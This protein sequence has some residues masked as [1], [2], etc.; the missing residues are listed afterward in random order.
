MPKLVCQSGPNAGH[1][2]TIAKDLVVL[3]RQ[4]S[5]DVQIVDTM[6]SRAHCH[7]RRDGKLWSLIDLGSRNGTLLN[8]KRIT[9]RQLVYGDRIRIGQVEYVLVK[10]PGDLELKDLLSKYDVGEKLGEGGMGIVYKA[11]QR[12]M[13]R[14]V[15]LKIL[16]PKYASRPKFVEQF[17]RE[18]RAAGQLNHPNIIQVHDVASENEIHYFSMEFVDGSTCMQL[19]KADGPFAVPEA[20]EI[21]RQVARALEYAH[22][23]RLIHQDIKP[24]NVMIGPG[25]LVK[26]ADLGI[27]KTFD[28][29][30]SEGEG[31]KVMGTPHYMAPEAGLGKKIDHRVDIYSLGATLYHLL[32]GKTPY[33]GT[34]ATE[35]LKA[36]VMDPLP[37]LQDLNPEVSD[38]VCAL[39]ERMM[40]KKAEERY[41]SANE[42]ITELERLQGGSSLGR[43]R[44]PGHETMIL[45][46]FASGKAASPPGSMA[47]MPTTGDHTPEARPVIPPQPAAWARLLGWGLALAAIALAVLALTLPWSSPPAPTP[48]MPPAIPQPATSQTAEAPANPAGDPGAEVE[49]RDAAQIFALSERLRREDA[50]V[51]AR[52]L[53]AQLGDIATRQ[54][55]PGNRQ[56]V[57]ELRGR[58]EDV[59]RRRRAI[60]DHAAWGEVEAE[61]HRLIAERNWD[62]ALRRIDA[63]KAKD[64][65]AIAPKVLRLRGEIAADRKQ[66]LDGLEEKM[67]AAVAQKNVQRLRELREGLPNALLGG[68]IENRLGAA[69][70][71]LEE[72]QRAALA[73]EAAAAALDLAR[74]DFVRVAERHALARK[75]LGDSSQGRQ[76]DE[77]LTAAKRLP[78]LVAAI[79]EHLRLGRV[80]YRGSLAGWQNPDLEGATPK[81]LALRVENGAAVE[82]LWAKL[83]PAELFAVGQSVLKEDF[84]N[85]RATVHVL[86]G[87]KVGSEK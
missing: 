17:I 49:R 52:D 65:P 86:A 4:S 64:E 47:G 51:D 13:A 57:D 54:L 3:G 7:I 78:E 56:K 32:T 2:Y 5:C 81:S 29:A 12:S 42:V 58:L 26:L 45:R 6:A 22:G 1:E 62:L 41:Q 82:V 11:V 69:I 84:E 77:Y 68:E 74:W 60:A 9:E 50:T 10:L 66:F 21:T 14:T 40:A 73:G 71:G 18:A 48:T 80:R 87:A 39:V 67:Q 38:D 72:Q 33:H 79:G 76:L 23:H 53:G 85:F 20:L 61:G 55:T 16:T 36:H 83:G 75:A 43:E 27:S 59:L 15:A 63:F 46:R 44:I 30:E 34:N 8:D 24:D 37:P 35:V 25:N 28:E 31:K 70:V 19:L